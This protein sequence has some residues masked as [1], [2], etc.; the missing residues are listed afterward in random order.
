MVLR[1]M[2]LGRIL[3]G[4]ALLAI[5]GSAYGLSQTSPGTFACAVNQFMTSIGAGNVP[6][7][8]QPT[9]ANL[10]LT[11]TT[12]AGYGITSP[13]P[14]AQGG[15][16]GATQQ[17][18]LNNIAPTP[19]RAGDVMYWN[20]SNWVSVAGNNSGTNCLQENASGVPVFSACST[21]GVTSV[22][23]A[24]G[25]VVLLTPAQGR[26]T[27]TT[28]TPVPTA[29]VSGQP[30]LYYDCYVGNQVVYFNGSA[31]VIDTIS[32][33]EVVDSMIS[34]ASAGQVVANNVYDVW[35]V[36]GG[37]NRICLAMSASTGGGGG[38][39]A[40]T[41]GSNTARGTGYTA[42]DNTTRPYLTNKNSITNCFNNSTNYGPVSANQGTYLSTVFA[43]VNG[44][45]SF[46]LGAPAAGGTAALLGVWNY[47]NRVNVGPKVTDTT[48]SYTYT[49]ATIRQA[50]ASAGNQIKFVIGVQEDSIAT[51]LAVSINTT[52]TNGAFPL[53][54]VGFD[55]T[56]TF[57]DQFASC[58][59]QATAIYKCQQSQTGQWSP[60]VGV[61]VLS[62][63]EK[64]DGSNANTFDTQ[65]INTLTANIRM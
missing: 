10:A 4:A 57:G 20:G 22:N 3:A 15:T 46:A 52:A 19:T 44:G 21:S 16:A 50:A 63:N 59:S 29:S 38:F 8:T 58:Y 6:A 48:A 28:H 42:L 53:F 12:L 32:S 17:A 39:S 5:L 56:T 11:P 40:D 2:K 45:V 18:A 35:W 1:M 36:H 61:H 49:T 64:G 14:I 24:V 13:L 43:D 7:C 54:G 60:G 62:S 65:A 30:I 34:A 51:G 33:C 9:F 23:T 47:Y 37:A 25:A 41:G 55:S 26:V 31:D 27:V